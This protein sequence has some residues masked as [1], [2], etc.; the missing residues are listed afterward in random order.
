MAE[1][2]NN[3]AMYCVDKYKN[4]NKKDQPQDIPPVG[5]VWL[6]RF[7]D[8]AAESVCKS[9]PYYIRRLFLLRRDINAGTLILN[10]DHN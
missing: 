6:A 8:L 4:Y 7:L 1:L 5:T 2:A 9:L 10:F 3:E